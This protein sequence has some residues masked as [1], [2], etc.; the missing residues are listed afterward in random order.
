MSNKRFW[1]SVF[2][3]WVVF[4]VT[5]WLFHGVWMAAMYE[6]TAQ[7]WRSQEEIQHWMPLTWIGNAIFSWA[8]VWIYS[9]G[10]SKDN[11]WMQAFRYAWAI[12]LVSQIH[13]WTNTWAVSPYPLEMVIRW[14][15]IG[16][17]QAMACA[18]VMTWTYK[19]QLTW[20]AAHNK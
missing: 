12:I 16:V 19:P 15:F 17:I 4:M 1:W 20:Q 11:P 14:A 18:F 6:Q 5:E 7:L 2:A 13:Q 8:F 10:I 3:V 9:K